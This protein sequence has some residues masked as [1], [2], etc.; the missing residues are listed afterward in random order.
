MGKQKWM[1]VIVVLFVTVSGIF[2]SINYEKKEEAVFLAEEIST[3]V[4]EEALEELSYN[5]ETIANSLEKSSYSLE[6][7]AKKENADKKQ[8]ES[9]KK[10]NIEEIYV[11]I[12]G[13]VVSPGVYCLEKES[14][15][16]DLIKMAGGFT[17]HASAD[18]VNQAQKL[19]DGE[20]IYIPSKEE[21]SESSLF[22]EMSRESVQKKININTADKTALMTLPGIGASKAAAIMQYREEHGGFRS[23]EELKQIE[24]IKDGVFN[25][26]KDEIVV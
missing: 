23:I 17:E 11:H 15:V 1:I 24:G 2:Y 14:R 13:Q 7:D 26:I 12:C 25:K 19:S 10:Q 3:D 4:S 6:N 22:D 5:P 9:L 8:E 20:K 21:V 18:Y 16:T